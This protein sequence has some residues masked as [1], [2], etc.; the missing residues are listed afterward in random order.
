MRTLQDL[1]ARGWQDGA[2]CARARARKSPR[3]PDARLR[4]SRGIQTSG[5]VWSAVAKPGFPL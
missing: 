3:R 2:A 1:A 4:P 5:R